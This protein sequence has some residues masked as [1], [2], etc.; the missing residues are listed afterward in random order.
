VHILYVTSSLPYGPGEAFVIPEVAAL[1][2]R[3]HEVTVVPVHGRGPVLHDDAHALLELTLESSLLSPAI[4]AGS[5]RQLVRRPRR[6]LRAAGRLLGSRSPRILL[7]NLAVLPKGLWLGLEVERRAV[8]HIHAHWGAT[9]STMALVASELSGIPWSLT[10]HRW[11]IEEDNL[12]ATKARQAVF[13]RTI[14]DIGLRKLGAASRGQAREAFVLHMGV[15]V[16]S[17]RARP[18]ANGRVLAAASLREVKG[19]RYLLDAVRLVRQRG[20]DVQLDCVG[21]G[22]LR[23]ELTRYVRDQGLTDSVSLLPALP[24]GEL[25][26]RLAAG[27][28]AAAVLASVVTPSG[29]HEGIP[30]SLLE[31]M[32]VGVPAVGTET[33]GIPTL[34][35]DGAGVLVPPRDAEALA[36]ALE[37]VLTDAELRGALVAEG[38]KRV[39]ER[40]DVETVAA[41]LER[42]FA[43]AG[44]AG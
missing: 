3:G 44:A 43:A 42:R 21:D 28:W 8:D 7:K 16:P 2:R 36:D 20:L 18:A 32:S 23:D 38:R 6:S 10:V 9:S 17:E 40:F 29:E 35:G 4:L 41:E 14:N 34:L 11:D 37:R 30:V 19:H 24:H 31:A 12:L 27:E 15:D 26:E 25:L 13:V 39:E 33:G 1:R 5:V 22:P